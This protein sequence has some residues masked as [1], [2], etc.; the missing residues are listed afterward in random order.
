MK[1][2]ITEEQADQIVLA[3][4]ILAV[5]A[6][7]GFGFFWSSRVEKTKKKVFW[8]NVFIA[9][10]IGPAIWAFW[11]VYNS[12]ENYYGLDS[13]KALG[14]NFFIAAVLGAIF[15]TLFHFAPRWAVE[16]K[17]PKSRK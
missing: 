16:K 9:A 6:S 2:L 17:A 12:I 4:S 14:I 10:L 8:V 11:Q 3:L 13:V 7:I 5:L 15:F 1:E